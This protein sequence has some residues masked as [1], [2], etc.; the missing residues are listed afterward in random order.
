MAILVTCPRCRRD[1]G[2]G[3]DRLTISS[4]CYYFKCPHC[5]RVVYKPAERGTLQLL[6][7]AGVRTIPSVNRARLN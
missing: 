4:E 2:H 3:P 5:N 1:S 6:V 7:S